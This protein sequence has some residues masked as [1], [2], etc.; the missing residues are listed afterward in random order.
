MNQYYEVKEPVDEMTEGVRIEPYELSGRNIINIV[1]LDKGK[2]DI[3]NQCSTVIIELN[4]DGL[5]SLTTMLLVWLHSGKEN[6]Y[7]LT[8]IGQI[9]LGYNLGVVL[10]G[11]SIATRFRCCDLGQIYQYDSRM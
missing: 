2:N 5:K 8:G 7:L 4:R 9:E 10:T 11:D 1:V 6:E 3:T